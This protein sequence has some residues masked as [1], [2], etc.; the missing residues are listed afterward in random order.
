MYEMRVQVGDDVRI[1]YLDAGGAPH[2]L[3]LTAT[4]QERQMNPRFH[5][6]RHGEVL[7]IPLPDLRW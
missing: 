4:E 2:G 3:T 7:L 6:E 1:D 5:S